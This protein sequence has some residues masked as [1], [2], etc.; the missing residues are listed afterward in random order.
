MAYQKKNKDWEQRE[1]MIERLKSDPILEPYFDDGSFVV[2]NSPEKASFE[3]DVLKT[4]AVTAIPR[5]RSWSGRRS[6]GFSMMK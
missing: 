4:F 5:A 1:E 3:L 2:T 6:P